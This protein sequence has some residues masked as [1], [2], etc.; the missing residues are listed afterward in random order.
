[1]SRFHLLFLPI[2]L[3]AASAATVIGHDGRAVAV[4]RPARIVALNPAT[5]E[6]LADLGEAG[7]IVGTD[8]ATHAV[9]PGATEQGVINFGHPYHPNVEAIVA[10]RPDLVI[11]TADSLSDSTPEQLRSAGLAVLVLE[12]S[13]QDGVEGL[14]RRIAVV[15]S[16]FD[17]TIEGRAMVARIDAR[18]AALDAANA[19]VSPRKSVFFLYTHGPGGKTDIYGRDTGAHWLIEL[20]GGH[21][22]ADFTTGIKPLTAEALVQASPDALILLDRSIASMGGI[23]AIY[24]IAGVGLTPAGRN[25]AV[26]P[27]DNNIRWIGSHFL[28]HVEALHRALYA[29]AP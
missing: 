21:N 17:K 23:D 18:L 16:A 24:T 26:T 19:K 2:V 28:D 27:V 6:I 7:C 13:T 20:A 11:G 25:R 12:S 5:V 14:K 9:M 22:A 3:T 4:D 10:A 29:A 8:T 1:M 15:A